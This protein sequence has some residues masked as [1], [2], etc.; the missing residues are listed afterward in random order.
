MKKDTLAGMGQK[1]AFLGPGES[2][3][4][5]EQT[6]LLC[7]ASFRWLTTPGGSG[8][9]EKAP[10]PRPR[11][12]AHLPS[13]LKTW[14]FEAHLLSQQACLSSPTSPSTPVSQAVSSYLDYPA[15]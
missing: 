15:T 4:V 7:P 10:R 11:P 9:A 8:A 6:L 12:T 3:R 14:D 13:S 5:Y 2:R 1:V